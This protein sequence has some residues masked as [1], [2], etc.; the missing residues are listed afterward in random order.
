[1][2]GETMKRLVL[3]G[4][5]A[6][7]VF[8]AA[9]VVGDAA[10]TGDVLVTNGSPA[11]TFP[12]NKQNEPAVAVDAAHPS[13]VVA[14]ANDEIDLAPC[15]TDVATPDAPCPFTPGV[16]VSGVYFSFDG[17][18]T[19]TQPT[20]TGWS[21]RTGT[22][23]VGSIGTLPWYYENGLVS[24]GDPAVAFGPKPD[25][26]GRF[27]W[28]NGSR[29]YY[30]NLASNFSAKSGFRGDEAIAVSR[31]DDVEAAAAGTKSAWMPPVIVSRQNAALFSDK[32]QVWA[33]NASSSPYF[34]N[35]YICN[36]AFRGHGKGNATPEPVMVA[37]STDGG[38]SWTQQ[39]VSSATNNPVTGGRQGCAVRTDSHGNVY[40]F[41]LGASRGSNVHFM[42]VSTNGGASFG[43]PQLVAAVNVPGFVDPVSGD[44]VMDGNAGARS[45][46]TPAPSVDIANGAPTG[47][48][49]PNTIV[50]TWTDGSGD[51]SHAVVITSTDGGQHWSN[52]VDAN[53]SGDTKAMYSAVAV[54]PDGKT[55]YLTYNEWTAAFQANETNPRPM[56]GVFRSAPVSGGTIGTWTT[57]H[58]GPTGDARGSSANSL[59]VEFLGDYNYVAANGGY[60]V[61]VWNDVRN[62]ADCPAVD[63]YRQSL[64]AQA[65]ASGQ[66]IAGANDEEDTDKNA[67]DPAA[68][69][70]NPATACTGAAADFGNSDIYAATTAP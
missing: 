2:E 43:K 32:D 7:L 17:G 52:P 29:L 68:T 10:P 6:A 51:T 31:T 8:G 53:D 19:W 14:G 5:A 62:A 28:S 1:M 55:V 44:L 38:S 47:A 39:Q 57:L 33:D 20:Y 41:W 65:T 15:G 69:T 9:A 35:V 22:E 60:G 24:G 67:A 25:A 66:T 50:D 54:T 27:S 40:A 45:D 63:G 59:A 48:N 46:L 13:V 23:Q 18:H 12:R 4:A 34:G 56:L 11:N 61:A 70:P 3:A 26:N 37:R 16:G 49:A 58:R 36:V 30:A 21:A 64:I 42:A